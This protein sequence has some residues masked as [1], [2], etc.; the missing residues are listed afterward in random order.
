MHGSS[1]AFFDLIGLHA[2]GQV[3]QQPALGQ[4]GA[5]GPPGRTGSID[6][7]R[8]VVRANRD[9]RGDGRLG[10]DVGPVPV[11]AHHPGGVGRQPGQQAVLGQQHRHPGI[12]QHI[13]QALL[14]VGRIERHIRRTGLEDTQ[15][16][17]QHIRRAPQAHPHPPFDPH[18]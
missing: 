14:G 5:L 17:H 8:Q 2:P 3:I 1:A 13:G 18:T 11:Q 16:S 10:R 12:G 4:H 9:S 7:V 6:H 15:Q